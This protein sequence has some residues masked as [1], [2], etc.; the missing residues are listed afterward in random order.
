[1]QT[2]HGDKK[3]STNRQKGK[4]NVCK[5]TKTTAKRLKTITKRQ[6]E[7]QIDKNDDKE[8]END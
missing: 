4:T 1:M 2:N 7:L 6:E 5:E 8:T 3:M